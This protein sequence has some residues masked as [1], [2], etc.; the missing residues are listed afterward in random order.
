MFTK[1]AEKLLI[2]F[3]LLL[4]LLRKENFTSSS[5]IA[6]HG[7]SLSFAFLSERSDKKL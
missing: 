6:L 1:E 3:A 2:K 5:K 7:K 4:G